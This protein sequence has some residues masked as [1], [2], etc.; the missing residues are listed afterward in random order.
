M[1][2]E[3]L[4]DLYFEG[5]ADFTLI[6]PYGDGEGTGFAHGTGSISGP[7]LEGSVRF[8]SNGHRRSDGN[9][10]SEIRALI[11]TEDGVSVVAMMTARTIFSEDRS[12]AG[13]NLWILFEAEDDRYRWLNDVLCI[14]EGKVHVTTHTSHGEIYKLHVKIYRCVNELIDEPREKQDARPVHET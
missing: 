2:L 9:M 5:T 8:Y 14:A 13:Q 12:R 11:E 10:Q 7:H 3:H 4:A 6:Q 1:R